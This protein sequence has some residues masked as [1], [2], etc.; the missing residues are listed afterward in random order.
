MSGRRLSYAP[1]SQQ[2]ADTDPAARALANFYPVTRRRCLC[3][4]GFEAIVE[5]DASPGMM[6]R[7]PAAGPPEWAQL[8]ADTTAALPADTAQLAEYT[9]GHIRACAA[10]FGETDP[11]TPAWTFGPP[12]TAA[13]W[14]RRAAMEETVHL[15][16]AEGM[17]GQAAPVPAEVA[18][19]GIDELVDMLIP[20][21]LSHG[22]P[23]PARS[24]RIEPDG[25]GARRRRDRRGSES[26]LFRLAASRAVRIPRSRP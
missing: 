5:R 3:G 26:A 1:R 25:S 10:K 13:F 20:F 19:N 21:W 4:S 18:I 14:M 8:A 12:P 11:D 23:L 15:R 2:H 6:A 7:D 24:L 17:E 16:D 22:P 9:A